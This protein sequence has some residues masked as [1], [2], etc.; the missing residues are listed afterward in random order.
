MTSQRAAGIGILCLNSGFVALASIAMALYPGG[1]WLEPARAGHAFWA[2]FLCDLLHTRAL[3]GADNGSGALF[4]RIAMLAEAGALVL[5]WWS[6]PLLF[7][8]RSVLG[9]VIRVLG[10]L[11]AL[12]TTAVVLL[13]SDRFGALHGV[14]VLLASVP[15]FGAAVLTVGALLRFRNAPSGRR[16]WR[17]RVV[18]QPGELRSLRT[19]AIL[20]RCAYR[21]RAG[22]TTGRDLCRRGFLRRRGPAAAVGTGKLDWG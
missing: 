14:M 17:P 3:S 11:S 1:T 19:H 18:S 15:G 8:G 16:V 7:P 4:A 22:V 21:E 10:V 20:Q 12:G 13:P 9:K 5:M 6:A 2:N